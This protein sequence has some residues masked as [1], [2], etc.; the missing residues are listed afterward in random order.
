MPLLLADGLDGAVLK[1]RSPS[2]ATGSYP[3]SDGSTI[4][5]FF[6]AALRAALPELPL[7]D[8][9][10]LEED[11]S[12]REFLLAVHRHA[13]RSFPEELVLPALQ[14]LAARLDCSP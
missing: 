10:G 14:D 6:T 7:I 8:E 1:A 12:R 13:W 4:D 5:G 3:L 11:P 9:T 2:C